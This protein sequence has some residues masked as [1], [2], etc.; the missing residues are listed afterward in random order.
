MKLTRKSALALAIASIAMGAQAEVTFTPFATYQFFDSGTLEEYAGGG[1][2]PDIEDTDGYALALG[3]RFTPAIGVEVNYGRTEADTEITPLSP[4][5]FQMRNNR[6]SLDGYYKFNAEGKFSPFLLAGVGQTTLKGPAET[7][8][9]TLVEAGFGAF[10]HFNQ[11]VALRGEVRDLHNVDAGLNDQL[12]MLGLE[13][14]TGSRVAD[15]PAPQQAAAEEPAPE[16]APAEEAPVAAVAPAAV[17]AAAVVVDTDKDGVAD[18]MD[19]CPDSQAGALVDADGCYQVLKQDVAVELKVQFD[20]GKATIKGDASGEIQ[21]VANF[22]V[23]Y[24]A[25]AVTIE[26]HTDSS[27]NA[28]KNKALSLQRAD[29][30]KAE[31]VKLGA[32]AS[33]ITTVGYGA[34]KPIADNKTE[35]GRAQNRR[36]V[37]SAKAQSETIQ[38]KQ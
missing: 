14:S 1:V 34:E 8:D 35:A 16:A 4:V 22:M 15:E 12:V 9:E 27:G 20:S 10:Y 38:M 2:T 19:K 33:R 18:G 29:A 21:R 30:V 6:L 28:A 32:D 36:V 17:V 25:V 3:Y 37:A 23:K 26:G 7:A 11:Y 24:P 31:I 5:A 13:F